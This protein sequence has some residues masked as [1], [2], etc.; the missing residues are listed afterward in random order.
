MTKWIDLPTD[1][2]SDTEFLKCKLMSHLH[3]VDH[4]F[5][6]GACLIVHRPASIQNFKTAL[7]DEVSNVLLHSIGLVSPPHLK[8]FHF[9]VRETLLVIG[10]ELWHNLIKD[11]HNLNTLD[12]IIYA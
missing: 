3:V 12:V 1:S 9:D 5:V 11:K 2:W 7:A 4:V 6:V 8:E 10:N